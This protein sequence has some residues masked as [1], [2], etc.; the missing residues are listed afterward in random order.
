MKEYEKSIESH[1][2]TAQLYPDIKKIY[3]YHNIGTAYVKN[4]QFPE[5]LNAFQ[6][7][8][9]L[10]VDNGRAY[11]NYAMYY[12]LQNQPKK[13]IEMLQKAIELG[14]KDIEWLRTDD[15]MDSL[16]SLPEFQEIL[17]KIE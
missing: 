9:K 14:Y 15:S 7:F 12:A 8:E 5:A 6:E 2:R 4:K 3:Y 10:G 17:K 16:R 13:A 11:R 1:K